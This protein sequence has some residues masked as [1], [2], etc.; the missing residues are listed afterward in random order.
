MALGYKKY[1][2]VFMLV[3]VAIVTG[4]SVG[5]IYV[6]TIEPELINNFSDEYLMGLDEEAISANVA[7]AEGGASPDDF[8]ALQ[9]YQIAEYNL[10]N[11]DSFY[12]VGGGKV[13]TI[14]SQNQYSEKI[15]V[16][17]MYVYNKLSKGTIS[18]CSQIVYN[19]ENKN[20]KINNKGTFTNDEGS[21]AT[22]AENG[23][24]EWSLEDYY[25][26]FNTEHPEYVMPYVICS[27][28]CSQKKFTPVT[29]NADGNYAFEIAID[30]QFL[31]IAATR[32]SSEIKYSSNLSD[33]PTW[34]SLTMTVVVDENFN[35][36]SIDYVETYK[37]KYGPMTPTVTDYF[38]EKF[39][40]GED[41][42]PISQV[43]GREVA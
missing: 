3:L 23:F 22:F 5:K 24:A 43:L 15:K 41:V 12:K 34:Q 31:T 35:F 38:S 18:I 6:S 10:N 20:L 7:K 13:D 19:A 4:F 26:T 30:G 42:P 37:M 1:F 33:P 27:T 9:L 2:K 36:V 8:N 29:K 16:G 40:F 21:E 39:Y 14:I 25:D 17:D 11:S 32:Y 28:T